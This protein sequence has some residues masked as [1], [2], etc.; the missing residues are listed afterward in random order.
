VKKLSNVRNPS[1]AALKPD[2]IWGM[3]KYVIVGFSTFGLDYFINWL[4]ISVIGINYL[5]VGYIAAPFVLLF[6][7]FSHKFWSFRDVGS[8]TGK[9]QVQVFR[10]IV[11]IILNS[12][13][14]MVL[15][16]IFYGWLELPLIWARVVCTAIGII[17][18]FPILRLWVYKPSERFL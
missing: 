1:G 10:Y 8:A 17:W 4:L 6:N 14:N 5:I 2:V 11:L 15:M 7:F 16:Y 3:V 12:I 9:T 13:M 18:T